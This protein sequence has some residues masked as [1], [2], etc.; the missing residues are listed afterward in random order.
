MWEYA[1]RMVCARDGLFTPSY[2]FDEMDLCDLKRAALQPFQWNQRMLSID[3]GEQGCFTPHREIPLPRDP[4]VNPQAEF[5]NADILPGGRYVVGR[6]A[7][8]ITLW[9]LGPTHHSLEYPPRILDTIYDAADRYRITYLTRPSPHGTNCFRICAFFYSREMNLNPRCLRVYEVGPL[10]R[11]TTFRLLGQLDTPTMAKSWLVGDRVVLETAIG[12]VKH[13]VWD[14]T[15]NLVTP[16]FGLVGRT[17]PTLG[18]AVDD[19]SLLRLQRKRR[20][21]EGDSI[22]N[23]STWRIPKLVPMEDKTS[24]S[25]WNFSA[26]EKVEPDIQVDFDQ[27]EVASLCE[28]F[29]GTL[30]PPMTFHSPS[31]GTSIFPLFLHSPDALTSNVRLCTVTIVNEGSDE[32]GNSLERTVRL[33]SHD[34]FRKPNPVSGWRCRHYSV[35]G[36][37]ITSVIETTTPVAVSNT[38]TE[39]VPETN[40]V[41]SRIE[42]DKGSP[43]GSCRL[44]TV[45]VKDGNRVTSLCTASSR[46]AHI[47]KSNPDNPEVNTVCISYFLAP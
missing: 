17:S 43:G 8:F 16:P 6:S 36:D 31:V 14:V 39:H 41:H 40:L 37:Y 11:S 24:L 22:T 19:C 2:P 27:G 28:D 4:R 32:F 46:M 25:L 45:P 9:D 33:L 29:G 3:P 35:T 20:D 18:W 30:V 38:R 10:P 5:L 26:T 42:A 12:E 13:V 21:S 47:G 34:L 23:L 7:S 15:R 44:A 1:L